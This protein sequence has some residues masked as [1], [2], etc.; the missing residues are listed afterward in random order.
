MTFILG[1]SA[2]NCLLGDRIYPD[3]RISFRRILARFIETGNVNYSKHEPIKPVIN[4]DND[5]VEVIY[6]R[7]QRQIVK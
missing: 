6:R 1:E 2:R 7:S 3:I 5:A 4:E